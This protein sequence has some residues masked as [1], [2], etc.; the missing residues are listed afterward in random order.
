MNRLLSAAGALILGTGLVGACS[1]T[2]IPAG[3]DNGGQD[4]GNDSGNDA[5]SADGG[6]SPD[7]GHCCPAGWDMHPCTFPTGGAGLACHNPAMGC[8]SASTCGVGCDAVVTGRCGG[9]TDAGQ[10]GSG[11]DACPGLGCNPM[12]PNGVLKDANGC[13]T[14]D[15]APASL[16]WYTTCGYPVCPVASPDAG[17]ADAGDAGDLCP[18][19]GS[20]C[21]QLGQKCGT[22]SAANCGATLVC[23]SQDPKTAFGGC[24]ISSKRYKDGIRYVDDAQLQEL[25]DEALGIRLATYQYKP[26]VDDP[27]PTH[28]GFLIEDNAQT[29]AVDNAHSRV[30]MYGYFSLIVAGMQVQEKEIAQLRGELEAARRDLAT[31][32]PRSFSGE[33]PR[34]TTGP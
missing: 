24:P 9:D 31:C 28:L 23:A 30:D 15:C 32:R 21:S 13:D 33:G 17:D 2:A 5:T 7:A 19:V 12:C 14:C 26:Q 20:A 27:G 11:T 6:G 34:K 16:H 25:H 8:A 10:P 3:N 29:P 18:P 1:S 4:G 22:P